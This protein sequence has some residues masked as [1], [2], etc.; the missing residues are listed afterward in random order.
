M[1][2]LKRPLELLLLKGNDKDY[3]SNKPN[4]YMATNSSDCNCFMSTISAFD[5][6]L[7]YCFE[8]I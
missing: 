4:L 6:V 5:V 3:H 1:E 8:I 7:D 2:T